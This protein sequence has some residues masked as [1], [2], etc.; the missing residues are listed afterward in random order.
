[1]CLNRLLPLIGEIRL[2]DLTAS[3]LDG[4]YAT[5]LATGSAARTVRASHTAAKKMLGEALRL[6]LVGENVTG[7][8]RPPRPKAAR[9]KRFPTWTIDEL[10]RFL[11]GVRDDEDIALWWLLAWSGMRRGEALALRWADLDLDGGVVV[12]ARAVA[13]AAGGV[14]FEK[15]PKS[16]AGRRQV[17]VDAATVAVLREHRRTQ[18]A[19]RLA[20]GAGWR[21]TGLVF[22]ALDGSARHPNVTS[23][24]WAGLVRRTA[25]ALG[26]G[27]IRLH[28]LRH[29]HA[30]ALLAAGVRADVV[31]KRLGHASVAFTLDTY[32]HVQPGDQRAALNQLFG[33]GA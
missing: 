6:G 30:T 3:D 1:M 14:A 2:Q 4:A 29:S 26:L 10:R 33:G 21:G 16:A 25:P 5:L 13:V 20:I 18:A 19:R 11:D 8:A 23:E 27:V 28:D 12:V 9:A 24:R 32:G 17:D 15:E 22:C 7:R 31:T